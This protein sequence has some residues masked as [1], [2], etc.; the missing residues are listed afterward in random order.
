MSRALSLSASTWRPDPTLAAAAAALDSLPPGISDGPDRVLSLD[1]LGARAGALLR[2]SILDGAG[3]LPAL[4]REVTALIVARVLGCAHTATLHAER[5]LA[6]GGSR[7]E[8]AAL[9]ARGAAAP[10]SPRRQAIAAFTEK[11]AATPPTARTADLLGLRGSGLTD[12]EIMDL[13]TIAAF[14]SA[15]AR[16]T[17]AVGSAA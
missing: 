15:E 10:L 16:L 2:T 7:D 3:G 5:F 11:F 4:D 12:A 6:A 14:I 9:L 1:P 13:L 17:L 8:V